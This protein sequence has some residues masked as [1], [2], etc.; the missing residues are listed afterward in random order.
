MAHYR[1]TLD[2]QQPRE[3]VFAHLSDFS[4]TTQW[5]PSVVEAER[6]NGQAVG[7]G[8]EF[9]LVA[10]FLGRKN[11]LTYPI[12]E[13]NS[14][15]AV[16]FLGENATVV[17]RD[18]ITFDSTAAGTRVTYDAALAL[19]GLLRIA[20]PLLALAFTRVGDRA[21]AGL[22]RT[23][24][25]SEPQTLSPLSGR[26][27]DGKEYELPGDLAKQ[28]TFLVVAFRREQQR[29]VDQWPPWLIDL[30]QHRSDVAVYELPVLSSVYGPV[31][32]FIDGG[33]TRGIPDAAARART[34]TVYTD[35]GNVARNLGLAGTDTITVLIVEPS[36]RILASEVGGFEEH[37]A[38][39]LAASLAPTP[40]RTAPYMTDRVLVTGATGFI[41]ARLAARLASST[42]EVRC[43]VRDR[44]G[45][46]AR[47]LEHDGFDLH[48][49]DV[50]R[51]ETLRGA[52]HGM[53]VAYYLIHSM[54][55]GG[56]KDFAAS[57]RAAATAFA[58]M[59]RADGIERIIYL[60]GLGDR[61]QSQHLRSRH[62]TALALREDGPP[63][64]YLRAGMVV[65][66]QSESYRTLRY[67]VQRLPAM[68]AP[69]WLKNATQPI[70][71]DDTL[72]YL[73]EALT[74]K[75]SAGREI[76]I[77]GPDVLTYGEMLDRMAEVLG[78]RRRPRIPVPLI[79]PWLSSLWIGLVTPVDA[80]VARPLIEGL[81]T[82]TVV[83][84]P[85]GMVLFD[86]KPISF[87]QALRRAVAEDPELAPA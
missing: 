19:K 70:A 42:R 20:D 63:L 51:P 40:S 34:I 14:P 27:L 69:A 61:P 73:I 44:G 87:D 62:E 21:L 65:G 47:A 68:I 58:R 66:P 86:T 72:S 81:A 11:E 60:G 36:G 7:E 39:R 18:R 5:D 45:T 3:D 82:P 1:A 9:R 57:E 29:L 35:V 79:T 23:L 32:W 71:I 25:P 38:E 55:R 48:E 17:S 46:R 74:V 28:H 16:T 37:K 2:I 53:D 52:G 56:A 4:T 76:Q 64:T 22:R 83:T 49:G 75:A 26:A 85:S 43:L 50:L 24:A 31:R 77:G 6:V 10:E 41:G 15:H 59:A 13:Y 33:M 67:L 84:D 80:G 78:I 30:E 12:V 8:T 54:G